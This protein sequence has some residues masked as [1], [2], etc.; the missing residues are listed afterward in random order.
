MSGEAGAAAQLTMRERLRAQRAKEQL[1]VVDG[2][3]ARF[4]CKACMYQNSE[5]LL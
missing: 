4:L 2:N 3:L 5:S 1:R